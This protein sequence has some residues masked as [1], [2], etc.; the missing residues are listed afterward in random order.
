MSAPWFLRAEDAWRAALGRIGGVLCAAFGRMRAEPLPYAVSAACLYLWRLGFKLVPL[1]RM[2]GA[3]LYA[4]AWSWSILGALLDLGLV[5]VVAGAVLRGEGARR[6]F[7]PD[8]PRRF[9]RALPYAF[10]YY[11][12]FSQAWGLLGWGVQWLAWPMFGKNSALL[13]AISSYVGAVPPLYL[14][15]R[16][17][18]TL[19]GAAVG[20]RV[21]FRRSW[22]LSR[23]AAG[24]LFLTALLWWGAKRLPSDILSNGFPFNPFAIVYFR[25]L[26][27]PVQCG[28][29]VLGWAV[30]AAWYRELRTGAGESGRAE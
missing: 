24:T 1:E 27:L 30:G 14:L 16:F 12:C 22:A 2:T 9:L 18:F 8:F 7:G 17:G 23:P 3:P 13:L 20:D 6:F 15:G 28:V 21:S 29:S 26:H 19:A 10:C 4:A 25:W 11:L 5:V